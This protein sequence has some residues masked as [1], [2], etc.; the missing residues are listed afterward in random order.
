[1]AGCP[2]AEQAIWGRIARAPECLGLS[3]ARARAIHQVQVGNQ[4]GY[5]DL[6]LLLP[7]GGRKEARHR[8]GETFT[9]PYVAWA[10]DGRRTSRLLLFKAVLRCDTLKTAAE[11]ACNGKRLR[12]S[13]IQLIVAVDFQRSV[14]GQR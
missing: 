4:S 1:M 3:Y 12:P 13:D 10:K 5:V 7:P 11:K 6:I 14:H 8:R 2:Y 9:G